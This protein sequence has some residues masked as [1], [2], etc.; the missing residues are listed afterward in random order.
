MKKSCFPNCI[1][2]KRRQLQYMTIMFLSPV[3]RGAASLKTLAQRSMMGKLVQGFLYQVGRSQPPGQ[4]H[5]EPGTGQRRL[6]VSLDLPFL[7][8]LKTSRAVMTSRPARTGKARLQKAPK[9]GPPGGHGYVWHWMGTGRQ[10]APGPDFVT[11]S[12]FII[13]YSYIC[14]RNC[15]SSKDH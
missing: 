6:G 4:M 3:G 8:L 5:G 9:A 7:L 1:L 15:F 11:I 13:L 2:H 10:C 12:S 14:N